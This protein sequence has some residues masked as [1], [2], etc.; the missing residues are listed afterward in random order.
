[1]RAYL[2]PAPS[3]FAH[4]IAIGANAGEG[5][6]DDARFGALADW[7]ARIESRPSCLPISVVQ[8]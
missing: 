6:F 7:F 4:T 3:A 8:R 5:G 2:S 1:M